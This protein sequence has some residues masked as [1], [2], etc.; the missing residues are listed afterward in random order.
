MSL[1]GA[2]VSWT[3]GT[4]L[5]PAPIELDKVMAHDWPGN[6]RELENVITRAIVLAPGGDVTRSA[7]NL[8]TVRSGDIELARTDTASGWV[9]KMIRKSKPTWL[10]PRSAKLKATKR[11]LHESSEYSDIAVWRKLSELGLS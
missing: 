11:R 6:V 9:F 2:T 4:A 8:P 10:R 5:N 1:P 7:F 3:L